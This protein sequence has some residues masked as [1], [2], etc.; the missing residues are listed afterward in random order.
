MPIDS[1]TAANGPSTART[2]VVWHTF[3]MTHIPRPEDWPVMPVDV[4][5]FV[6]RPVGFF[7]RN[8]TLD[9]PESRSTVECSAS[10]Q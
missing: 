2:W 8:P 9:I 4:N 1:A 6:L 10:G 5:G 3:G 7:D